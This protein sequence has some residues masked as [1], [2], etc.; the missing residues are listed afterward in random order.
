[1]KN[2]ALIIFLGSLLVLAIKIFSDIRNEIN[3][4]ENIYSLFSYII[5]IF[6]ATLFYLL[7][8]KK[9]ILTRLPKQPSFGNVIE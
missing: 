1:M 6:W 3:P 7:Y 8:K 2:Y 4:F 9:I 5:I